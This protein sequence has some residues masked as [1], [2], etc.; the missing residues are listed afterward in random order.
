VWKATYNGHNDASD[1]A[2]ALAL[3]PDGSRVFVTGYVAEPTGFDYG[4][5]AYDAATG[6]QLWGES[7][8][9][10]GNGAD[11]A[12]A[13]A[14]SPGGATVFVTGASAGANGEFDYA[15]VA[16]DAS[17][18]STRWV[19]R[20]NGPAGLNDAAT[21][22]AV[23]PG[24]STVFVTGQSDG[25]ATGID[26]ATIAY[27][28]DT[29]ARRWLGR[30]NGSLNGSD[31]G[32]SIA[33]SPGGKKVFVTGYADGDYTTL[34]YR[35]ATGTGV[36][37]RRYDGP[38]KTN[39]SANSIAVSPGGSRVYVTGASDGPNGDSDWTTIAYPS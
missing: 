10:A 34:A 29:G 17:T 14:V 18:G 11:L 7:Y 20:Y 25:Q 36:W 4:T 1:A 13:V 6:A 32:K 19:R 37:L 16:Y 9:G 35:A 5:V 31:F 15:T 28:A 33:V 8:A 30:Y 12:S 39:D 2:T 21:S 24:G 23:A 3:S 38:A 27:D 22:L 26:F